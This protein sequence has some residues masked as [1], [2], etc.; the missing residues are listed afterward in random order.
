MKCGYL[1]YVVISQG[2]ILA[3]WLSLKGGHSDYSS[4]SPIAFAPLLQEIATD[5]QFCSAAS[6]R[7][8]C[9][10]WELVCALHQ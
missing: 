3:L 8:D 4:G 1:A 5:E 9:E 6:T 2:L 10:A 7:Q